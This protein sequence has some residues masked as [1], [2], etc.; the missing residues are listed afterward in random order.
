MTVR[1]DDFKSALVQGGARSNKFRVNLTWPN[2]TIAGDANIPIGS[3]QAEA[4]SSFMVK[5]AQLPGK[6]IG[7]IEVP[8]RGRMLK[9]AGDTT[10]EDWTITVTNDNNFAVRNAFERWQEAINGNVTNTSGLG[11]DAATFDSYTADL[12]VEQ[13][14]IDGSVIK[15]YVIKGAWPQTVDA[16]DVSYDTADTIEEFGVTLSYQWWEADVTVQA[17]SRATSDVNTPSV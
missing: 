6:T 11:V 14:G 4:L 7:L 10:F 1:I 3:T 15:R 12:E 17:G 16:I 5:G 9:V 8:F 2:G 13:L